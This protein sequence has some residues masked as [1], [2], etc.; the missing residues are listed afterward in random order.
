LDIGIGFK[1]RV[2]LS[3]PSTKKRIEVIAK[4]NT[5]VKMNKDTTKFVQVLPKLVQTSPEQR[6]GSAK[7][8]KNLQ[9]A[10]LVL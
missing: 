9:W 1:L 5:T 2:I 8:V 7:T 6:R 10:K 4:L 3:S